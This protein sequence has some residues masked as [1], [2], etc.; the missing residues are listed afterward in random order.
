MNKR[1]GARDRMVVRNR[2]EGSLC[3]G[4]GAA[5]A[6]GLSGEMLLKYNPV[7]EERSAGTERRAG[8]ESSG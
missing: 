2:G 3:W 8:E 4:T 1:Q 5:L 7:W 6:Q